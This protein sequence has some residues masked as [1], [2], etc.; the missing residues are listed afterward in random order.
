MK[1]LV[2][3]PFVLLGTFAHANWQSS[4][5]SN[6]I[7][8]STHA[9][10]KDSRDD[11]VTKQDVDYSCGASSLS[12][13]LTYFYQNPKT[14]SEIL[15]DMALDDV[16]ASFLDLAKVSEKYGYT[17]RGMTMD[18]ETLAKIKIPAIVYVNHKRSDHFS[19]VR[20]IDK[21]NVYLS[22]SSWGNRTLTRR[23]FEKIWL[24]TNNNTSGKVLLI[25]P[26]TNDQKQLSDGDFTTIFDT[27]N[28][29]KQSPTL[30]RRF[31]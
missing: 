19:V 13:I 24:T 21:Q 12:T 18:Y 27:Q 15:T 25:L 28:L 14:E 6:P 4:T 9:T 29:L 30:F 2:F 1:N 8:F 22:D 10:W 31:L 11:K 7:I 16:M 26:T 20:A 17:A 5:T 23:Q 3:I